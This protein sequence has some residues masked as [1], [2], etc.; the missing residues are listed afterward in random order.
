MQSSNIKITNNKPHL[1]M[2]ATYYNDYSEYREL[3]AVDYQPMIYV[4]KSEVLLF[5]NGIIAI[6]GIS[7]S[8]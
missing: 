7:S 1:L 6:D 5:S 8:K 2:I 3:L 4:T